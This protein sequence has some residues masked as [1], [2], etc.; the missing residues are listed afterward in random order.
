MEQLQ[1]TD[2]ITLLSGQR[3]S[4]E[5]PELAIVGL[6][7][8]ARPLANICRFAGQLPHFYSVAQHAVNASLIMDAIDPTQSYSALMHDTAE[9]FTN[10]IVTPL[11]VAVPLF[12]TLEVKI[13]TAMADRF[14]FVYPLSEQVHFVDR[15][16]LGLEMKYLRGQNP[17]EHAIL[18]GVEFDQY[19][20]Y[21]DLGSWDPGRAYHEFRARFSDLFPTELGGQL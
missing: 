7:D 16:M 10:D 12:K 1:L 18:N 4:Y 13:E 20:A 5:Q 17:E 3:F 6:D 2:G 8:I 14:K 11:K 21:V 19:I 15:V 9:A